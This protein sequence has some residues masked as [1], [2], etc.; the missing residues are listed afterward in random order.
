MPIPTDLRGINRPIQFLHIFAERA[1]QGILAANQNPI[2]KRYV[3]KYLCS[4]GQLF[5]AVGAN[6]PRKNWLGK[7]DFLMGRKLATYKKEEPPSSRV[8][9]I[10]INILHTLDTSFQCGSPKQQAIRNLAWLVLF[11]LL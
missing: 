6:D 5:A 3:K 1:H 10:P 9:P 8:R 2:R 11:L 7:I 4:F